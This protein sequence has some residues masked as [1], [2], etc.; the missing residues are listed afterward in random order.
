MLSQ[1]FTCITGKELHVVQY[2]KPRRVAYRYAE[3]MLLQYSKKLGWDPS[4]LRTICMVGDNLETDIL[5]ANGAGGKWLSVN[6]LSGV[7][8]AKPA[9]RTPIPDDAE[10][11]W[12]QNSV[13]PVPHYIAPTLD[14]FVRELEHFGEKA[15]TMNKKPYYGAPC[16]V[17]LRELY[18][19]PPTAC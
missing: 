10:M 14:H 7:G 15:I 19:L 5:G 12:L 4:D 6:V 1:T 3:H 17:D 13:S 18:H 8:S 11:D 16:P 2:G 9:L